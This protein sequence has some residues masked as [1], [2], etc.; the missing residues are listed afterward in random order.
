V[1]C[2]N[3]ARAIGAKRNYVESLV[4]AAGLLHAWRAKRHAGR[5]QSHNAAR[6]FAQEALHVRCRHMT[7]DDIACDFCGVA[8][9]QIWW[10]A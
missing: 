10:N 3:L 1:V 4:C 2:K 7:F 8:G 9:D 6:S 5:R